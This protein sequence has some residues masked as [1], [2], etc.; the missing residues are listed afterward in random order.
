[1]E[2]NF[3]FS[4]TNI[5]SP[6]K[7]RKKIS[8]RRL[9]A[10]IILAG[11][12]FTFLITFL[13]FLRY[14]A[15]LPDYEKLAQFRPPLTSKF[16]AKDGSLLTEYATEKRTY[17]KLDEIPPQLINAFIAAEDKNFWHHNG[18]DVIGILRAIIINIQNKI[19]GANRPMVGASTITQQVAK[20]FFL[21]SEQSFDRK[22]KEMI[23]ALKME[24]AFSKN[25]ILTL[26]LNK[27]YLGYHSYGIAAAAQSYF[28]KSLD[29]LTLSEMAF[30]AALPKGPNNY[31]PVTKKD[32]AISRRNWVLSRM[33]D[34]GYIS[35]EMAQL[36]MAEDLVVSDRF[37][38]NL[39]RYSMYFSEEVRKTLATRFSEDTL[40][41]D[42]FAVFTTMQ[43]ELQKQAT[44]AL[45]KGI[46]DYDRR[47]GYRGPKANVEDLTDANYQEILGTFTSSGL[48]K[49][50]V[51]GAVLSVS[52]DSATV[53]L[54]DG[55]RRQLPFEKVKWAGTLQE[56]PFKVIPPTS[57]H[58]VVK[59]GDIILVE[60]TDNGMLELRQEPEVEGALVAMEPQS[61]RVLALVGGFAYERSVFNR[62]TQALRQ[63]G[64]TIKP[65]VYLTALQ[66]EDY[67][68]FTILLDAPFVMDRTESEGLWKPQ[69]YEKNF[70]G[71]MPLRLCLEKSRN[72]PTL[73]LGHAMGTKALSK[74][75]MDFGIYDHPRRELGLSLALGAGETT[76]LKMVTAYAMIGNGGQ[77]ISPFMVEK[78]Q[79]RDGKM[80]YREDKRK[81]LNCIAEWND[82]LIPPVLEDN[83]ET[84]MDPQTLY[85]MTSILKGVVNYGTGRHARVDDFIIAGKTG[86][87]DAYKDSWFIGMTPDLVV[88][89]FF[90]FDQPKTLGPDSSGGT[91]S[92]P[93]FHNF[94][95]EAVKQYEP[96]DFDVPE[97]ISFVKIN[98]MT[99]TLPADGDPEWAI[100]EEAL[101][102]GELELLPMPSHTPETKDGKKE[103]SH[104]PNYDDANVGGFY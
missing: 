26:Y 11:A 93:T 41:Q 30:L 84:V 8:K 32:R 70:R 23:L 7:P 59:Q 19:D 48:P 3:P 42:G 25:H 4:N 9:F 45:R 98:K 80:I 71:D 88:G 20:N 53:G 49:T 66:R 69:N 44:L 21:S 17:V 72:S 92:A 76:L 97:G 31:N 83:R 99:G 46:L 22:I 56:Q 95:Q 40:Y 63:P 64:S 96:R 13:L 94:M 51:H 1:M 78:V 67:T 29:A 2:P 55:D 85:Q 60:P 54:L 12:A 15:G 79:D 75:M 102:E 38:E 74:T 89:L 18:I 73:R 27:I 39:H 43:P 14:S 57:I 52:K 82:Q 36:A 65:F 28:D 58:S 103:Q 10:K 61:G 24:R 33:A 62:A 5:P 104:Q 34:D 90:G 87:S 6:E 16:Y 50:W 47:H 91:L 100:I 81:C 77:K 86:T 37:K 101:K 35:S 68:P